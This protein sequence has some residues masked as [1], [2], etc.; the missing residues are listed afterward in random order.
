VSARDIPEQLRWCILCGRK[1]TV[2]GV[3]DPET[4]EAQKA[5][6]APAGKHRLIGYGLC[7]QHG[8]LT[9]SLA[10]RVESVILARFGAL[11]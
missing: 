1:A 8:P 7:D 3:W 2:L 11:S 9:P 10:E 6:L 4:S 5:V